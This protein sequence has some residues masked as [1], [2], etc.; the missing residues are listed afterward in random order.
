VS[1][2]DVLERQLRDSA[3]RPPRRRT[4]L[5]PAVAALAAVALLLVLLPTRQDPSDERVAT[6]APPKPAIPASR[7][8][9][10]RD[11]LA[12][13]AILRRPATAADRSPA[14][15]A[16]LDRLP[17]SEVEGVHLDA[18]RL[19]AKD[20]LTLLVP[21]ERTP[22]PRMRDGLCVLTEFDDGSGMTC[23]TLAYLRAHG[24]IGFTVPPLGLV[25]DG[26][27]SVRVRV[28][29]GRSVTA[30]VRDNFYVLEAGEVPIQPP[31]WLDVSGRVIPRR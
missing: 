18:V 17:A 25:P 12:A 28:R 5:V 2:F 3:R 13:F 7:R 30:P 19:L 29:G 8:P 10:P 27:A 22:I 31:V 20:R 11:Q 4:R 1:A 9:V 26:V 21:M 24:R 14:V 6:P 16:L 23:G 15:R